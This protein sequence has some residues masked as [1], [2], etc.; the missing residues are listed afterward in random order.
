[1]EYNNASY[2]FVVD[3]GLLL[4]G[5]VHIQHILVVSA[6]L[7]TQEHLACPFDCWDDWVFELVADMFSSPCPCCWPSVFLDLLW[8]EGVLLQSCSPNQ[9]WW[10]NWW[11][12]AR[13]P[14]CS[15][16]N[17]LMVACMLCS[18]DNLGSDMISHYLLLLLLRK[19]SLLLK[20]G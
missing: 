14:L 3:P 5:C 15:W 17:H 2:N 1:M 13:F 12:S 10:M 8:K 9:W 20:C 7:L 11:C 6:L 18:R 16:C 4:G 19:P